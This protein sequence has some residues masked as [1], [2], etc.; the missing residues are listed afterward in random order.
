MYW[1]PSQ[2]KMV[3]ANWTIVDPSTPGEAYTFDHVPSTTPSLNLLLTKGLEL[4]QS[5]QN[6][7]RILNVVQAYTLEALLRN[8]PDFVP[9]YTYDGITVANPA[10]GYYNRMFAPTC[11]ST[12]VLQCPWF[13]GPNNLTQLDNE[14]SIALEDLPAFASTL[15]DIVSK[16][17]AV[18]PFTGILLRFSNASD[19]YMSVSQ[20]RISCHFE[21]Y[22]PVR[23][24]PYSTAST[25]L[26]AYQAI[27]QSLVRF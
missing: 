11:N 13:H 4:I 17:A 24:N 23:K 26:A 27:M 15:K 12:G 16:Y 1:F 22:M 6:S 18:F 21:F 19:T 10:V 7:V 2:Q 20:G 25:G 14:I 5:Q 8:M 3:I 9:I